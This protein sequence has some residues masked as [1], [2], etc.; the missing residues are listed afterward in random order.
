MVLLRIDNIE[1]WYRSFKALDGIS[2]EACRGE[3]LSVVG[4]NGSGKTTLLKVVDGIL[5][6]S[7]GSVYLD[8][9]SLRDLKRPEVAKLIGYV[10]QRLDATQ[11]ITVYDFVMTGRKP[12]I[13]FAP[14]KV[15]R[16]AVLKAIE[17]VRLSDKLSSRITELSGGEFQRALIARALSADPQILL[18]DE[19]TANLDPYYQIEIL[20]LTG[21][22]ARSKGILVIMALHDLTHAY[23]Y[24]DKVLMM[25]DGAIYAAGGPSEVLTP[26]NIYDVYGIRV[27]IIRELKS[28]IVV[29]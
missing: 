28:V 13:T 18:L 6:P 17:A 12:Y 9:K 16:D 26:E 5:K 24:S 20:R 1:F 21:E 15:D 14:A 25:K 4:P 2:F 23:R 11:P 29:E 19:P 22:L 8:G 10:P 3:V 7:R 27:H